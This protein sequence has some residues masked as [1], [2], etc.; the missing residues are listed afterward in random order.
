MISSPKWPNM[1]CDAIQ[2]NHIS[3]SDYMLAVRDQLND[4][5]DLI[6]TWWIWI[7]NDKK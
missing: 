3:I 4:K 6:L 1:Q 7:W 2:K 5:S